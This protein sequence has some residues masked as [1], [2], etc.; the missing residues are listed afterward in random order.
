MRKQFLRL[1]KRGF[2]LPEV[3]VT[4]TVVAVLAAVVVPAVTQYVSKGNGP[5]TLSDIE[6]IQNA[7]TAFVA[8]AKVYPQ[9]LSDLS[10]TTKPTYITT[11][12]FHGPYLQATTVGTNTLTG[13]GGGASGTQL[14]A[15]STSFTSQGTGLAFADSINTVASGG[16]LGYIT[17]FISAPSTCTAI[18]QLDTIFDKGDGATAGKLNWSGGTGCAQATPSN[19]FTTAYFKLMAIG[20]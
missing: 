18:L 13:N 1:R 16:A 6:Q 12:T 8:D 14:A 11:G 3:L 5:A 10:T 7:I 15:L 9:R 19:T 4:V 17:L 20:Q 2:T